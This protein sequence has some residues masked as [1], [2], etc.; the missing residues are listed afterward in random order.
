MKR[1]F[2]LQLFILL[3]AVGAYS[4]KP[5]ISPTPDAGKKPSYADLV[6]KLKGGDT[7]IDFAALRMAYTETKE[8][9]PYGADRDKR[10]QMFAAGDEKRYK[11]AAALADSILASNYLD[12]NAHFGMTVARWNL[13]DEAK[14]DFHRAVF[15]GLIAS[16]QK[17]GDGKTPKTAYVVIST[18]EEYVL[19]NY[20]GYKASAQAL[21][22]EGGHS[23]DLMTVTN[24]KTNEELKVYFNIDLPFNHLGRSLKN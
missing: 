23:Y 9:S 15:L 22:N 3:A 20:L 19:F 6:A 2:F 17:S 13:G 16:I 18:D 21:L 14:K 8:Y 7:S 1:V 12:L 11:D 10:K 4:Q 24:T 5:A